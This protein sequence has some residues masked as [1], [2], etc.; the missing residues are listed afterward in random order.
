MQIH[1]EESM[2]TMTQISIRICQVLLNTKYFKQQNKRYITAI[3]KYIRK[4]VL[5][6][7]FGEDLGLSDR[8]ATSDPTSC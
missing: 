2:Y 5:K 4:C 8:R 1:I 6:K 3:D 7:G